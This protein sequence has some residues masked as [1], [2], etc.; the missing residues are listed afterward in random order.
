MDCEVSLWSSWSA[1]SST[2][3]PGDHTR[4]RHVV[5]TAAHG[6]LSCPSILSQ[7]GVCHHHDAC[8][9][10]CVVNDWGSWSSCAKSCGR[11]DETRKRTIA[12]TPMHGGFACP[13]LY[14]HRACNVHRCP[15]DCEVS[16]YG[17]WGRCSKTCGGGVQKKARVIVVQP[18]WGGEACPLLEESRACNTGACPVDCRLTL[19]GPWSD[20]SKPCD[21]GTRTRTR[22]VAT[23][24]AHGGKQCAETRLQTE[25]CHVKPCPVHC[26]VTSWSQ[27]SACT[28]TCASGSKTRS[29]TVT[30]H[31]DHGGYVCPELKQITWCNQDACPVDCVVSAWSSWNSFVGGGADV[32]R[33]RYVKRHN[34][35]GGKA[36]PELVESRLWHELKARHACAPHDEFGE[37]STCTKPCGH[38]MRYR[39][40]KHTLCS[41]SAVVKLHLN[42]RQGLPCNVHACSKGEERPALNVAVPSLASGQGVASTEGLAPNLEDLAA[43]PMLAPADANLVEELVG[44]SHA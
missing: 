5:V 7:T 1:C 16:E 30:Q 9:I 32:K 12:T 27:W 29:R 42:F 23:V 8:P 40:R 18:G 44:W 11:G 31:A 25:T 36:C 6:G 39:E 26:K 3:G 43:L 37:W 2:C 33:S 20:C 21:H 14:D 13:S 24:E 19:W 41:H 15:V 4:S 34:L 38:G 22:R 10:H 17:S 28:K 35:A